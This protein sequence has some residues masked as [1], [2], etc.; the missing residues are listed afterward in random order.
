MS[1]PPIILNRVGHFPF[2]TMPML[3]GMSPCLHLS[4]AII[5]PRFAAR[6]AREHGM[7]PGLNLPH[8]SHPQSIGFL[9]DTCALLGRENQVQITKPKRRVTVFAV[10]KIQML[11]IMTTPWYISVA[12]VHVKY[13]SIPGLLLS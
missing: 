7:D 5:F 3:H 10:V 11:T 6:P 2:H 4:R 8:A 1:C 12:Q 13:S 9:P